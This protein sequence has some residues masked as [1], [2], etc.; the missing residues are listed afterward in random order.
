MNYDYIL[1]T[2]KD[3]LDQ[4]VTI[5]IRCEDKNLNNLLYQRIKNSILND[6]DDI[7]IQHTFLSV[8]I[9]SGDI[10]CKWFIEKL[11]DKTIE[12]NKHLE[13]CL[14]LNMEDLNNDN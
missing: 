10:D 5:H 3:Y 6:M 4:R 14:A 9:I 8:T 1:E 2:T 13:L 7:Q 12:T 11:I